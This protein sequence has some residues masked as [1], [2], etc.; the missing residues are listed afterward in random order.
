M[1]KAIVYGLI[2]FISLTDVDNSILILI[3]LFVIMLMIIGLYPFLYRICYEY[4]GK[5]LG[6]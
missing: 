3:V 6:Y 4:I 2:L 5:Q 1:E